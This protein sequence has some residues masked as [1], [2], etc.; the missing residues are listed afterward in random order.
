[1]AEMCYA[2]DGSYKYTL[3]FNASYTNLALLLVIAATPLTIVLLGPKIVLRI[4]SS[5][6]YY[7]RNKTAGRKAQILELTEAEEKEFQEE[8]GEERDSDEWENVEAYAVGTAKNGEKADKEWDGII[9]F[10]HPFWQVVS[11]VC[12]FLWLTS[13]VMPVGEERESFG[14][15]YERPRSVGRMLNVLS[16]P[17]IM[18]LVSMI[19]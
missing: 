16:I 9:G 3:G 6:G 17:E 2:P 8:G 5:F 14:R 15:L 1:M 19:F 7:L 12:K 18:I 11:A 13:A 10:F 4:G